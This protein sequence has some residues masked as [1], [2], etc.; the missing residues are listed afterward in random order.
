MGEAVMS[1]GLDR[2]VDQ[3]RWRAGGRVG[4][5]WLRVRAGR[6]RDVRGPCLGG[7]R[8]AERPALP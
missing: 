2:R 6:W 4:A 1:P 3:D 8:I 7:P 5:R